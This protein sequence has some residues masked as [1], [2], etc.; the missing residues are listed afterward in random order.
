[1]VRAL[2]Q[3]QKTQTRRV[4]KPQPVEHA[5]GDCSVNGHMGPTD[6]LM[7]SVAPAHWVRFG[8]GDRLWVREAWRTVAGL[9]DHSPAE[10][11]SDCV[12]EGFDGPWCPIEYVADG[13]RS[14]T[15][16]WVGERVGRFRQGMHMPRWISRLTLTV[17]DVRVQRLQEISA[18]D[19]RDEGVDRHSKSVRQM[20][21][22]GADKAER[23]RIYLNA[24]RWEYEQ[25]WDHLN[26]GRGFAWADNPWIVAISFT[27]QHGNIEH[28]ARAVA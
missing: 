10:I 17:T 24:C 28:L 15:H 7:R 21:L 2:L 5:S 12:D 6:F 9:D 13:A 11:G 27:V 23:D 20:W 8:I 26:A 18:E 14:D 22:F 19:A 25:L 4:F 16:H 3:G 1:M